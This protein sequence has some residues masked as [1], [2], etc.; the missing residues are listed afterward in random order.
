M[1]R[2][3]M[4]GLEAGHLGVFVT[5]TGASHRISS[6]QKRTGVYS[7]LCSSPN[8]ADY[9]LAPL[10]GAPTEIFL[11]CGLRLGALETNMNPIF[12]LCSSS[13]IQLTLSRHN[14]T[15]QIRVTRG[16]HLDTILL[17]LP[18]IPVNIWTCLEMH[19]VCHDTAGH[20]EV[21][22]NGETV[23]KFD[24]DTQNV[25]DN[26]LDYWRI[27]N[28]TVNVW[29]V[30]MPGYYDD[31]AVND[32]KGSKNNSWVGQGGIYGLVPNGAGAYSE[33]TPSAG[34]NWECVDETPPNDDTDYVELDTVDH[35]DL[36]TH[37]DL[38]VGGQI[39]AVQHIMRAKLSVTGEGSIAR[40]MRADGTDY[41]GADR[42][43]STDYQC[44][45]EIME[46]HPSGVSWSPTNIASLE[47]G[48]QV[49]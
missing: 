49:R 44:F 33:L 36:Y 31:L 24:G 1:S 7:L 3:F 25:G 29:T 38:P 10:P 12:E 37:T 16:S 21:L 43:L 19:V 11:R 13:G 39:S 47:S 2:I 28:S 22:Y 34:A 41:L 17:T 14:A 42:A 23:G 48:I 32:T 30:A 6:A 9:V 26:R 46:N 8:I 20:I 5:Q 35:R 18:V 45:T 15:Q 40:L 27:G 4:T